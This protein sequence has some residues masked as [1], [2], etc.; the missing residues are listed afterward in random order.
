MHPLAEP[1][2]LTVLVPGGVTALCV[3]TASLLPPGRWRGSLVAAGTAA[4]WCLGIWL[5]VRTPR[6]P[7]AQAADWQFAS[8]AAAGVAAVLLPFATIRTGWRF[9]GAALFFTLLFALVAW[10]F[11]AGLWPAP[12]AFAWPAGLALAATLNVWAIATAARS[13]QAAAAAFGLLVFSLL[14]SAALA[15]AGSAVLGHSFGILAAVAGAAWIVSWVLRRQLDP[16][17]AAFVATT[18]YGGLLA[19]GL[20]FG[21]L[22]PSAAACLAAAWPTAAVVAAL[23]R[24]ARG[25][26]RVV[27]VLVALAALAGG[28]VLLV[29]TG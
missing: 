6:W 27:F 14:A 25:H 2:L 13:I 24:S 23:L 9:A 5:A 10:R 22:P 11:L 17:P 12:A 21:G 1:A 16:L 3:L 26:L 7:P 29:A 28:A 4:G 19:Q 15:L 20:L 18:V 8:V